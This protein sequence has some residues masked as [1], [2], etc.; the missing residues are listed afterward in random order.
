MLQACYDAPTR[1]MFPMISSLDEF[2]EA[3]AILYECRAELIEE[4]IEFKEAPK[5][6]MMVE[7]PSLVPIM[8]DLAKEA[9]FF[10]IGTN[11]LIQYIL[12][13]D[14]TNEK[15][16]NLYLPHHPAVLRSI[17]RVVDEA[18]AQG[19][20]VAVCG[21]MGH[22]E[23]YVPFLLGI[24]IRILSMNAMYLPRIQKL[25]FGLDIGETERLAEEIL[26]R[27]TIKEVEALLSSVVTGQ[28]A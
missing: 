5:V 25:I 1:I 19:K 14:R 28:P 6:G 22:Q 23:L 13:V 20:E 17:K 21:A 8:E 4:G 11:D 26:T 9:D 12:G 7:V 3:R 18:L 2:R 15:V 16:A 27:G 24:G 10:S